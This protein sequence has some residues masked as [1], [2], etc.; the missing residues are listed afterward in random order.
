MRQMNNLENRFRDSV[1]RLC[2]QSV[3]FMEYGI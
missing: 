2:M 1:D 3:S